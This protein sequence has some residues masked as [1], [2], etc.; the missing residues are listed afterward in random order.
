MSRE[1]VISQSVF[2][3]GCDCPMTTD[4]GHRVPAGRLGKGGL[5]AKILCDHHNSI[6]APLD[7][8]AGKLADFILNPAKFPNRIEL[9]GPLL[10][11]WT[12]K[13]IINGLVAGWSDR[14]K[15]LPDPQVASAAFGV[16]AIPK[17]CG[18]LTVDGDTTDMTSPQAASVTPIWELP[19]GEKRLIG[20]Y[21]RVHGL[22]LFFA[23]DPT[24]VERIAG[25]VAV[26]S[27]TE[28]TGG[29]FVYRPPWIGMGNRDGYQRGVILCWSHSFAD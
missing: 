16:T 5:T 13:T 8:E 23:V 27:V 4:G 24:A 21:A 28:G 26:E 7:N 6:L 20:A 3:H 18:L 1:H 14:R 9:S 22:K 15:W 25:A 10:E 19:P 2:T 29:R 12:L 11:R 17:G